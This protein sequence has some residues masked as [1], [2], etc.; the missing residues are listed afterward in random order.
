MLSRIPMKKA[1][2]DKLS[3]EKC[4]KLQKNGKGCKKKQVQIKCKETCGLCEDNTDGK[5]HDY[6]IG[7]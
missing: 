5:L 3:A 2:K 6:N 1:C 4:E 7:F